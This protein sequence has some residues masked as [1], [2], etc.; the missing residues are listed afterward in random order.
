MRPCITKRI[1]TRW[2]QHTV[3]YCS[4]SK[5]HCPVC[6]IFYSL[7]IIK[8]AVIPDTPFMRNWGLDSLISMHSIQHTVQKFLKDLIH[9]FSATACRFCEGFFPC[10]AF[11]ADFNKFLHLKILHFMETTNGSIHVVQKMW[12]SI[13]VKIYWHLKFMQ[14]SCK[15]FHVLPLIQIWFWMNCF[16]S[17]PSVCQMQTIY[18]ILSDL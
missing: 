8:G 9:E 5:H 7:Q 14:G 17:A 15:Y 3:Q 18:S 2:N 6:S 12:N 13:H 1:I 16:K 4:I 10:T 11:C